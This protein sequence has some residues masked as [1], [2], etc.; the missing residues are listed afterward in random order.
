MLW[1]NSTDL[2]NWADSRDCQDQLPRLIYELIMAT[3]SDISKI[4]FPSG[5]SIS[6]PGYDGILEVSEGNIYIPKGKSVWETGCN[7]DVK[8]KANDDY[9]KRKKD[10]LSENHSEITYVFVSPRPWTKNEKW[11]EEKKKEGF[12]KDVKGYNAVDLEGWIKQAPAVGICLGQHLGKYPKGVKSL[13]DWWNEWI[14]STNPKITKELV[15]A[16]RKNQ[17]KDIKEKLKSQHSEIS[18]QA[19]TIDESIA[20]LVATIKSLPDDEQYFYLS[21]SIVIND[22]KALEHISIT[23][24]KNKLLFIPKFKE[25]ENITLAKE[26]GHQVY[27]PISPDNTVSDPDI[28]LPRLGRDAFISALEDMGLSNEVSGNYSKVTGRS[29]SVLR[30]HLMK[31]SNQPEWAK[32]ESVR[33]IIHAFLFGSWYESNNMDKEVISQLTMDSYDSF[34]N[35]LY[36]MKNQEDSP[37]LKIGDFW[38]IVSPMDVFFAIAPCITSSDLEKFK[39][40]ILKVFKTP[41]TYVLKSKNWVDVIL[42][43]NIPNYSHQL[44]RGILQSL[45]LIAVFG[46]GANMYTTTS[47]QNWVDSIIKE[48]LN[49]ADC[50][51]WMSLAAFLPLIA[52]VS[53]DSFEYAVKFSLSNRKKPIMCLFEEVQGIIGPSSQHSYLLWALESLSWSDKLLP[54]ITLILG[55][56]AKHDPNPESR[57]INRPK[58]SLRNIYLPWNPQTYASLED[59]LKIL[60]LLIDNY[61]NVAFN[62]L[63]EL[64]D[65][66]VLTHSYKTVWRQFSEK[67]KSNITIKEYQTFI[68]EI[69]NKLLLIIDSNGQKW[70]KILDKFEYLP[71]N[72]RDKISENLSSNVANIS[73][74]RCELWNKLRQI[75]SKHRSHPD[76]K[77]SLPKKELENL[78]KIYLSLEPEDILDKSYWLFDQRPDLLEGVKIEYYDDDHFN[79]LRSDVINKIREQYGF[80]GII[81]LSKKIK[82]P[83]CLGIALVEGNTNSEEE[84]IMYSLLEG[85]DEQEMAFVKSYISYKS[86]H[87]NI[88]AKNLIGKFMTENWSDIKIVNSFITFPSRMYVWKL[89]KYFNKT[90]QNS[91]WKNCIFRGIT[92]ESEDKIYFIEQ[93]IQVKRYFKALEIA[94]LFVE[95]M[96]PEL[97][98]R[99]LKKTATDKSEDKHQIQYYDIDRLFE[100]LYES[101]YSKKK[102]SEIE[103]LYISVLCDVTNKMCPKIL[104]DELNNNPKF[105]SEIIGYAY[106]IE[107]EHQNKIESEMGYEQLKQ[108]AINVYKLLHSWN[109]IPGT[110]TDGKI[111][112][113]KLKFWVD[114]ARKLC[115]ESDRIEHCDDQIGEL[116]SHT[117]PEN[118]MW[119]PEP[120]CK[121]IESIKS[122]KASMGFRIGTINKRGVFTKSFNEGGKQEWELADKFK[123]Y[124]KKINTQFPKMASLLDDIAKHYENLAKE[125]DE[126]AEIQELD[127]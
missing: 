58:N 33:D 7:K 102:I 56:L 96:P 83:H 110:E 62:L 59:R 75:I 46:D 1:V 53:P 91:Y 57:L 86:F 31:H 38:H 65:Q 97:I 94:S 43:E 87:D 2:K 98:A 108:I 76:A 89:L 49:N 100:K 47:N 39:N 40:I 118:D 45:I 55:E 32:N 93:M 23:S 20:F 101:E 72:Q 3:T 122:E 13:N 67:Q 107:N 114:D 121:I 61:P 52:E 82:C 48:L 30:R 4:R 9:N 51:L 18:V 60:D 80:K 28:I 69:I 115:E 19:N 34:S 42:H 95:E 44:K 6:T 84:N 88:W 50:N 66:D 12:W 26:E 10:C 35:K 27:I 123:G 68:E 77:W 74:N 41:H 120:V 109:I 25:I 37:I 17:L 14:T 126:R 81:K 21:K 112:Y 24:K 117:E 92:G 5:D 116:L 124:A 78:E 90:I 111:N 22:S 54:K 113:E 85:N 119:P 79:K 106:P 99:V 125:E 63:I 70:V 29:L 127:Y 71:T 105:F 8:K 11:C 15:L 36:L 16:G 104:F 103:L 73:L 64:I